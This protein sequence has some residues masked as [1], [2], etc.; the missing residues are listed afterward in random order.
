MPSSRERK[1]PPARALARADLAKPSPFK[2]ILPTLL[3]PST[4]KP[5]KRDK[6]K[7]LK[8][9]AV[10]QRRESARTIETIEDKTEEKVWKVLAPAAPRNLLVVN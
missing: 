6:K 5:K 10:K 9:N 1:R 4:D 7:K 3:Q 8:S 2:S